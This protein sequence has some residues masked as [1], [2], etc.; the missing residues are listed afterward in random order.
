M[1]FRWSAALA[2]LAAIGMPAGNSAFLSKSL[3]PVPVTSVK[4]TTRNAR[5]VLYM[6]PPADPTAPITETYGEGS[7][8]YRRTVY[9]HNEW[10]KHRSS[11]RFAKNVGSFL[12]SGIYKQIGGE[13][14]L[15]TGV[16]VFVWAWNLLVG[17]YQ[18][19]SGAMHDPI[20]TAN[21]AMMIGLPSTPFTTVSSSLG[22]LLAFRT[23]QSYK[24]WDEA[25]KF[26]GLNI[27]HTRDLNRMA[28]A[29][30]GN[31]SD[32]DG[33][34]FMEPSTEELAKINPAERQYLLGQ[35]SL[36]TWA[37]VRSMKRH[38]SPPAE[39][40]EDYVAE[41]KA[42]LSP[43]QAENVISAVHRPNRALYDLSVAI[44]KL[45]MH[46]VRKDAIN[47][48]LSI[49]EDTLGGSERLLS[50]PVPLF[51]SRHTAR[52]LL[53]WLLFLPFALYEPFANSW[54]HIVMIPST[55]FI[56]VCLFGIEELAT[57]LE[58]PFTILPM[59]GFCD[60]IGANCDE[61]VSW[62]GQGQDDDA[63]VVRQNLEALMPSR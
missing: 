58:E 27:N 39:D 28:T 35:V 4:P 49:F 12:N 55:V 16:A 42:R 9:T 36:M 17:G 22:L 31:Q 21:W 52:F 24:R 53:T 54:N 37:F 41:I 44:E 50:S 57:Q 11:D 18:D 33:T 25:R 7:R 5:S 47:T 20:I 48:N 60:K 2:M 34:T 30:Y 8:K 46:F 6:G 51:Y 1:I 19:L 62:A 59:Q 40:E 56:S 3:S 10:V 14:A 63:D 61:I 32:F 26:W 23:N 45:P 15:C 38:L 29:W 43:D 13:V